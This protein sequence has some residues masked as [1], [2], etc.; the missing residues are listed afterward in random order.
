[1]SIEEGR[2]MGKNQTWEL[3]E[4][5]YWQQRS[6]PGYPEGGWQVEE[7]K[8]QSVGSESWGSLRWYQ[9]WSMWERESLFYSSRMPHG[10]EF[11]AAKHLWA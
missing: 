8:L 1:M 11:L 2:S 5:C 4:G 10:Q 6:T 9:T 7:S 3:K